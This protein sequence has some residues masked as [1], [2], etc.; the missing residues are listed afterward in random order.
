MNSHYI[1]RCRMCGSGALELFLDLGDQPPA[2]HFL[3][4]EDEAEQRY[5]LQV[6]SC[7]LCGQIQLSYVV[8]GE[9]L[10]CKDYPYDASTA[11]TARRHWD[12]FA[13]TTWNN[14][15]CKKSDLVVDIGSNV[16]VLLQ[17]YKDLG[18]RVVGVDPASNITRIANAHGI[19]TITSFFNREVGKRIWMTHAGAKIITATNVF[20]HVDDLRTLVTD[21]KT[22]LMGKETSFIIEAPYV[23][24]LLKKFQYDTIYHEHLSYLS[25]RPLVNFFS[26][27]NLEVHSVEEQDFHGGSIRV[28]VRLKQSDK[29]SDSVQAFID[30]EELAGIYD[31]NTLRKFASDVAAQRLELRQIVFDLKR[32]GKK[33][34]VVSTPAKGMTLLNYCGLNREVIDFAT[35]KAPLKVGKFTPGTHLP[36]VPDSELVQRKPNYALLLA[37]NFAEEIMKNLA[38]FSRTGGKFIVPIPSPRIV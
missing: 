29:V 4:T 34:A 37:W 30:R 1:T 5:P 9:E 7:R 28:F 32:K 26:K 15:G 38:E 33:I 24:N 8:S 20:A 14:L 2:D 23:L 21:I 36:V 3:K 25:V 11:F 22:W 18:A 31:M 12:Q 27:L 6:L 10:Y 13:Q 19:E 17:A 35:E 16:G